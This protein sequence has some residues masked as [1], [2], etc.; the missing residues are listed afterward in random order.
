[1]IYVNVTYFR[2]SVLSRFFVTFIPLGMVGKRIRQLREWRNY[3]QCYMA[4]QL[5]IDQSTYS[6]IESGR[7]PP[8]VDRLERIAAIL[9]VPLETLLR[10]GPLQVVVHEQTLDGLAV[11]IDQWPLATIERMLEENAL[12]ARELERFNHRLLDIL[13][14]RRGDAA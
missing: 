10:K 8:R 13:E 14:R 5:G 11:P 7:T 4:L 3:A 2:R 12:R 6:R 9:E 1:M